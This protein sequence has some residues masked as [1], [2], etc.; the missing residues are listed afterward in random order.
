V[1][2]QV[3]LEKDNDGENTDPSLP[4]MKESS[5]S[6]SQGGSSV[7]DVIE[8]IVSE[9]TGNTPPLKKHK[10]ALDDL[11]GEIFLTKVEPAK[12]LK[13][14]IDFEIINFKFKPNMPL[15]SDPL[16]WWTNHGY[17][18]PLLSKL[19]KMYLCIP[20][21]SVASEHIFPRLETWLEH[22]IPVCQ[23]IK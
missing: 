6:T 10:C 19:A 1:Y 23:G 16:L 9:T 15:N 11:F 5:P 21:I 8:G 2:Y 17:S 20:V 18:Y 4:S 14:R 3:K 22:N 13:S 7:G 12:C